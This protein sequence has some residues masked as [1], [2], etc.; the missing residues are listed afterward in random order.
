MRPELLAIAPERIKA[1]P[2]DPVRGFPVPWFVSWVGDDGQRCEPGT[3]RPEF[4]LADR[5][6]YVRSIKEKRCW[7]CGDVLGRRVWF[8]IGPMCT[9]NRV[10]A[11]PPAHRDCA[12]FSAQA[13]PFLNNPA[14]ERREDHMPAAGRGGY[15]G[16]IGFEHNPGI[17]ALYVPMSFKLIN[18]NGGRL[19]AL[20]E[21]L[22]IL[23]YTCGRLATP[24][25]VRAGFKIGADR[26][27]AAAAE[28]SPAALKEFE[29]AHARALTFVPTA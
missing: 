8:V 19:F 29:R 14:M 6:K 21:P 7:V 5:E 25:E 3:G 2:V 15:F 12:V 18:A 1:L 11:D 9:I 4:R 23:W 24:A 10:S 27:R 20:G 13:C 16:G 22:E 17:T 28:Q 26:L